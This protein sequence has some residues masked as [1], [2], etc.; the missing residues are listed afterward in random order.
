MRIRIEF[1][2]RPGDTV[3]RSVS[4]REEA[5]QE[6]NR[7]RNA[8]LTGRAIDENSGEVIAWTHRSKVGN[9]SVR[10]A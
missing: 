6:L 4:S 10:I 5:V 8:C 9:W 2:R 1:N 7:L 3:K